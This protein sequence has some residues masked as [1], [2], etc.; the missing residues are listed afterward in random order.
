MIGS[1][2]YWF[3][4]GDCWQAVRE[5]RS[6]AQRSRDVQQSCPSF[7][8]S[9]RVCVS[10]EPKQPPRENTL[11]KNQITS[12]SNLVVLFLA[13]LGEYRLQCSYNIKSTSKAVAAPETS[14]CWSVIEIYLL[15]DSILA[16]GTS[17]RK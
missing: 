4:I 13:Y 11:S 3:F 10:L 15:F 5:P 17:R 14:V 8:K 2:H 1:L 6:G 16:V 7:S 9:K 12:I